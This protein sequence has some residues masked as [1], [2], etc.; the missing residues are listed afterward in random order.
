MTR[1]VDAGA[2]AWLGSAPIEQLLV[3]YADK[4]AGQRL[5][6][7]D[8]RF[9][10]WRRRYP[11]GWSADDGARARVRAGILE[12]TVCARAGVVPAEVLRLHWT[13]RALRAAR[14]RAA[15]RAA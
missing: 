1:L 14:R 15:E 5:G 11:D 4:R 13:G 3:A 6:S 12:A 7:L 9:A 2:D 8:A 10:G